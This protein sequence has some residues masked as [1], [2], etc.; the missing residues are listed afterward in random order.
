VC[1]ASE[2]IL[3][4]NHRNLASLASQAFGGQSK[5]LLTR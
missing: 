5:N 1:Q 2:I 3:F 4:Q